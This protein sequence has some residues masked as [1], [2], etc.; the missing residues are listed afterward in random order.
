MKYG[1]NE[2]INIYIYILWEINRK[3]LRIIEW[4]IIEE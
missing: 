2:I 4:K 1:M 3:I